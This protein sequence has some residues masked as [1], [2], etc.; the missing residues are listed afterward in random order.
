VP[1]QQL[2]TNHEHSLTQEKVE[3]ILSLYRD[4]IPI[5]VIFMSYFSFHLFSPEIMLKGVIFKSF[6][7]LEKR[8]RVQ[9]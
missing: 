1:V 6:S 3:D 5:I 2:F 8:R 4:I 9:E 7:I